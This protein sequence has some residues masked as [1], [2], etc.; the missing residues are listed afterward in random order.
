MHTLFRRLSFRKPFE[1][2]QRLG[3]TIKRPHIQAKWVERRSIYGGIAG[4]WH[5]H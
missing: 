1:L 5:G 2:G 4:S 3:Y